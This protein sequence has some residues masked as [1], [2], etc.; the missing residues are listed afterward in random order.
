MDNIIVVVVSYVVKRILIDGQ[1]TDECD[2]L[3]MI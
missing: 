3:L 1:L 2:D